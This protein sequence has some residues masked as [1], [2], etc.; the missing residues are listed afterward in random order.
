VTWAGDNPISLRL[1][2]ISAQLAA[3]QEELARRDPS[4]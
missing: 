4:G 2:E 1:A 3:L